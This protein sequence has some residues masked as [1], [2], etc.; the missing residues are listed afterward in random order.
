MGTATAEPHPALAPCST[1]GS[2]LPTAAP[3]VP[4]RYLR[5]G[6]L[7]LADQG[8]AQRHGDHVLQLGLPRPTLRDRRPARQGH[9]TPWGWA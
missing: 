2:G 7:A 6:A 1:W 5:P 4:N 9:L 8:P 3:R